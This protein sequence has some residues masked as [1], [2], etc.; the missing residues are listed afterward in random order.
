M[1]STEVT[2]VQL[3]KTVT[4]NFESN[5]RFKQPLETTDSVEKNQ[6]TIRPDVELDPA[7]PLNWSTRKKFLNMGVPSILCFVT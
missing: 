6:S 1:S 3:S 5:E 7:L 2:E 4:L